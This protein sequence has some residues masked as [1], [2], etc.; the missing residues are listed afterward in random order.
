MDQFY[1]LEDDILEELAMP[2]IKFP[3][4]NMQV[5]KKLAWHIYNLANDTLLIPSPNMFSYSSIIAG[6]SKKQIEYIAKNAPVDYKKE[7]FIS[8]SKDYKIKEIS[9]IIQAMDKDSGGSK[10]QERIRNVIQY[11][12]DNKAVFEF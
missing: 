8:I 3:Q 6:I 5:K 12:K 11:I 9:E 7:L 2:Y 4:N 1:Y 10:N